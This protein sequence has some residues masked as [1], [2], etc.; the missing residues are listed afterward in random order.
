MTM[1]NT[2]KGQMDENLLEK[3]QGSE[4]N[5]NEVINW[6]EYWLD[7]ELVHRSVNMHLKKNVL[8]ELFTQPIG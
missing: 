5:E 6:I 1:I 3:K 4:E 2:T 7:G 8:S